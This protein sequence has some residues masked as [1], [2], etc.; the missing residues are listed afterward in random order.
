MTLDRYGEEAE[1]GR[2]LNAPHDPRCRSGWLGEDLDGR[3]VPCLQCRPHLA[4]TADVNDCS[5][6]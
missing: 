3:P 5:K 4:R 2:V 6:R 1:A